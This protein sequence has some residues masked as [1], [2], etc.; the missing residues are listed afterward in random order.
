MFQLLQWQTVTAKLGVSTYGLSSN[1]SITPEAVTGKT[2]TVAV[3]TLATPT[4]TSDSLAAQFVL[5]G[6]TIGEVAKFNFVATDGEVTLDKVSF[7][8]TNAAWQLLITQLLLL[9]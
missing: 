2:M 9:L 3:P 6:K 8:V 4:L 5:G 1:I 7:E